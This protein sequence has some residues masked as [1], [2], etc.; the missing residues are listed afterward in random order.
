MRI[1]VKYFLLVSILFSSSTGLIA[2]SITSQN[3]HN[4][5]QDQILSVT[6]SGQN[7][8]FVPGCGT[9]SV[10]SFT[11]ASQ[12]STVVWFSQGNASIY[13]K[14]CTVHETK[15]LTATFDI[16]GDANTGKW[17]VYVPDMKE[18]T[19]L[20][21][22]DGFVITRPGDMTCDGAVNFKDFAV[23]ANNWLEGT[24]P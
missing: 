1:M 17:D 11:Q 21:L 20:T 15:L 2:Q 19:V 13:S 16:P 22:P 5:Q 23:L 7:T 12:T 14:D 24:S 10:I 9:T 4:V 8:T 3:T 6:I 18:H